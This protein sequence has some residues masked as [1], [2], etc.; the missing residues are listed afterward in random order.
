MGE[1]VGRQ[2]FFPNSY[3]LKS[4]TRLNQALN[5]LMGCIRCCA[6]WKTKLF[7]CRLHWFNWFAYVHLLY[8]SDCFCLFHHVYVIMAWTSFEKL[9]FWNWLKRYHT[10]YFQNEWR[11][12]PYSVVWLKEP[13]C[14]QNLKSNIELRCVAIH[15]ELVCPQI[16]IS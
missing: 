14:F 11:R 3:W 6:R 4:S 5:P 13:H 12:Y 2:R 9:V 8:R 7:I 1:V 15:W 10:P 16:Q